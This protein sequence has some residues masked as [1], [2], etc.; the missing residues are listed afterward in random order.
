M[1]SSFHKVICESNEKHL[2][3]SRIF[4]GQREFKIRRGRAKKGSNLISLIFSL[5]IVLRT[6]RLPQISKKGN[7]ISNIGHFQVSSIQQS[8]SFPESPAPSLSTR[9]CVRFPF[10]SEKL[11]EKDRKT[12]NKLVNTISKRDLQ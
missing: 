4:N 2:K 8:S 1:N 10:E 6:N 3:T 7:L 11:F 12:T 5:G 9:T